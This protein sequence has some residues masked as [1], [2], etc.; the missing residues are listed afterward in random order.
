MGAIVTTPTTLSLGSTSPGLTAG[1]GGIYC[2]ITIE[3]SGRES[4]S[5]LTNQPGIY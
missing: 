5:Q 1:R 4:I 2:L 3:V